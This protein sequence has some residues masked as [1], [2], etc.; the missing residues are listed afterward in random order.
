MT[1]TAAASTL[2]V[3]LLVLAGCRG[4]SDE[5]RAIERTSPPATEP[6][7][8]EDPP[9]DSDDPYAVPDDVDVVYAQSVVDVLLDATQG[10]LLDAFRTAPHP[11]APSDV[12]DA[13][14]ATQTP[15][16]AATTFAYYSELMSDEAVAAEELAFLEANPPTWEVLEVEVAQTNCIVV[17]FAYPES[18]DVS[19]GRVVLILD[20]R[21]PDANGVNPTPWLRDRVEPADTTG[22]AELEQRCAVD[23][24]AEPDDLDTGPADDTDA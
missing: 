2:L 20:E 6:S 5:P 12:A 15:Q 14:R 24:F 19:E 13:L 16:Q 1:R 23:H 10:P 4:D 21:E 11:V 18:A 3:G 17:R 9:T 22:V 8:P 7:E